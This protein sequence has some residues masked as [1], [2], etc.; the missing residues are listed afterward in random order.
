[1]HG[2][3]TI[4]FVI[5]TNDSAAE[6]VSRLRPTLEAI[7]GIYNYWCHLAPPAVVARHGY[8]DPLATEVA[9]AWDALR[10]GPKAKYMR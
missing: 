4:A 9:N 8:M 1:M 6:L 5:T 10:Q 3:R 2:R 7:E